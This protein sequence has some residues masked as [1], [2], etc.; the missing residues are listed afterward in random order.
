[1]TFSGILPAQ[2]LD[3]LYQISNRLKLEQAD[4]DYLITLLER[5]YLG[6]QRVGHR[7]GWLTAAEEIRTRLGP[8]LR[9]EED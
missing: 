4:H 2:L 1:M 3:Q 6:G 8:L 5:A 7:Q 9:D